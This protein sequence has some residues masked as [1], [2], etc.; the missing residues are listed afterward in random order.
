[1]DLE[2]L[3]FCRN[4][5]GNMGWRARPDVSPQDASGATP[6]TREVE[7]EDT[8]ALVDALRGGDPA[9][10]AD[11]FDRYGMSVHRVLVR[12]IGANDPESNDLLHDTFLRA[13]QS[14]DRLRKPHAL[15]SWL[16]SIAVFTAREW[17]RAR[18][19]MGHPQ[20]PTAIPD[21]AAVSTAPETREAVRALYQIL[22]TFP[23]DERIAFVLR[24]IEGMELTQVAD[25]CRVSLSTARR[26]IKRAEVRFR[27]AAPSY[28]ALDERLKSRP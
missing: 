18:R 15:K 12:I 13:L 3:D 9:A 23:G 2:P 26:R 16:H 7:D 10:P 28:P 8:T 4:Q 14:V 20:P 5:R 6:A 1:M 22:D 24:F 17:L 21:R 27:K 19:R 11:L 25:T